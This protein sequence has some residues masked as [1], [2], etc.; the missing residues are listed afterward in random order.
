LRATTAPVTL[1]RPRRRLLREEAIF[2][3]L[4]LAPWL[5]GLVVFVAGPMLASF[6][7]SLTTYSLGV[8]P[9]EFVGLAN[10]TRAVTATDPLFYPSILR[11]FEWAISYVP[12]AIIGALLV[13]VLLNQGLKLTSVFRTIFFM[14]HLTPVVASIFVWTWLLQPRFGFVNEMIWQITYRL[15]GTGVVG[16]G[17]FGSKEWAMPSLVLIGLWGAIGGNGMLIFLA[18]LQGVPKELYEVAELDGAG[19]WQRFWHVTLPMISPTLFFN[20]VLGIIGALQSFANSFI[21]TGGGPAY[22]TWFYALH[23]YATGFQFGEMGYASAL[24][25]IFFILLMA[26]T[27]LNFRLSRRWVHYSGEV[28]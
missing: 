14:P 26:I 6:Y 21:A 25:V 5:I 3:Y 28:H 20:L 4:F 18:G 13:A 7:L 22:A 15:T 24:A 9:P 16:P 17:W 1:A 10:F 19:V 27:Y 2:G 23:I 12:L 8:K 11:T